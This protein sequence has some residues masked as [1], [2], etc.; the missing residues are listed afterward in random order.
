MQEVQKNIKNNTLSGVTAPALA[1]ANHALHEHIR[2]AFIRRKIV[3]N[4][5]YQIR[6]V[7]DLDDPSQPTVLE[8]WVSQR[9]PVS[10]DFKLCTATLRVTVDEKGANLEQ[11][12]EWDNED[13][14]QE[15]GSRG[16][17]SA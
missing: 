11:H 8:V 16:P 15:T 10:R 3:L 9:F 4:T 14:N 17:E 7:S 12:I 2:K 13:E 6:P 1:Q 5:P